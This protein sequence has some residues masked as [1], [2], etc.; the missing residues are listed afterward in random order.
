MN[1]EQIRDYTLSLLG[2]T[3]DQ[4]FGDD[5]ITFRLEG[6]IFVC[7]WLG[8]GEHD[9]KETGPRLALKLSPERNEEL[10]SQFEAVT[11]AWH[12]NT[13]HWSDVYYE[14]IEDTLVQEWIRESYLLV[15]SK[16][17]KAM[18]KKYIPSPPLAVED[19]VKK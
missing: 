19:G 12:W 4:P 16:L 8:G 10:H 11:P 3:E 9:I 1:I 13:K 15:A 18:R 7:L 2:V 17:P 6:K 14:Q 5:I